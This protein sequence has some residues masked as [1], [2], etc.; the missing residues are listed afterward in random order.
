MFKVD[1]IGHKKLY[2]KVWAG[3]AS[4]DECLA[5]LHDLCNRFGMMRAIPPKKTDREAAFE[6]GERNVI[7]YILAQVN[8]DI[9]KYLNEREK[10]KLEVRND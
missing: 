5:V 8:Y 1:F 6:E 9:E 2:Q 3:E 7:L 4:K 10:Y